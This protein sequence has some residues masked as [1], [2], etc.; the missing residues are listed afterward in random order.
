M[1]AHLPVPA[2]ASPS[3]EEG[4][5][6]RLGLQVH[7]SALEPLGPL[8]ALAVGLGAASIAVLD[9]IMRPNA[10]A[11]HLHSVIAYAVSRELIPLTV[12]IALALRSAP[13]IAAELA[14]K[15]I[16]PLERG[17]AGRA[18]REILAGGAL[19]LSLAATGLVVWMSAAAILGGYLVIAL[20]GLAPVG[21][22]LSDILAEISL[23]SLAASL[24]KA[25]LAGAAVGLASAH[26][27]LS[28]A[29]N[30]PRAA[31]RAG[32]IGLFGGVAINLAI[33]LAPL[34][35]L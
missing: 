24:G 33:S 21:L 17:A 1:A 28:N 30:A 7:A 10:I 13:W 23:A 27:G 14:L 31:A 11:A 4:V 15:P 2:V 22:R 3:G 6:A 8:L 19:S 32:S 16:D 12:T 29:S 9:A 5:I 25:S 34:A 20:A 18:R 26:A 35:R